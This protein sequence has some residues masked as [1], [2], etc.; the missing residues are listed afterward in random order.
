[1]SFT[2]TGRRGWPWDLVDGS[3]DLVRPLALSVD[4]QRPRGALWPPRRQ[5]VVVERVV[6][7]GQQVMFLAGVPEG[8]DVPPCPACPVSCPRC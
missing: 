7:R 5:G 8:V 4:E 2:D 1:M 3:A 6:D